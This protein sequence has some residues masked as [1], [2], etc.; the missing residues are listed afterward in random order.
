M[1]LNRKLKLLIVLS[2][3]CVIL[4]G[5]GGFSIRAMLHPSP[6]DILNGRLQLQP[7]IPNDQ[8]QSQPE[9]SS[10]Q[11]QVIEITG[12]NLWDKGRWRLFHKTY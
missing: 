6:P 1:T 11:L 3:V 10:D 2:L 7:E 9:N 8:L 4:I 5:I 12:R